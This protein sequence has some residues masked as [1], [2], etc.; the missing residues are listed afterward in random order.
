MLKKKNR[1]PSIGFKA[2]K[3]FQTQ[4]LIL[5]ISEN[6]NAES[7][8]GFVVSKKI[9]KRAST[10]NKI[11][12]I[13]RSCIEEK[14]EKIKPGFDFLIIT[15]KIVGPDTCREIENLLRKENYLT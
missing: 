5:K 15:K 12:R 11:K 6:Q 2:E 9:D 4:E 13:L 1:L 10:R 8:F 14:L 7:R 3:T